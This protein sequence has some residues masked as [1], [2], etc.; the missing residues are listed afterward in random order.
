MPVGALL[1]MVPPLPV[2]TACVMAAPEQVCAVEDQVPPR[3]VQVAWLR[4]EQDAIVLLSTAEEWQRVA[5]EYGV[6]YLTTSPE[7]GRAH[8]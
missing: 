7:I 5:W 8:V 3:I 2:H 6:S 4:P 1:T